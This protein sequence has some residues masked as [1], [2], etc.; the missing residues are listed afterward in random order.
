MN[1]YKLKPGL[2]GQ[3]TI[4]RD[5]FERDTQR[6]YPWYRESSSSDSVKPCYAVCP[7]CDNPI[8]LIGLYKLPPNVKLPYGKHYFRDVPDLAE[9]DP[10]S[11]KNCP[12]FTKKI[13]KKSDRKK[14]I[15]GLPQKALQLL[16]DEFDRV[17]YLLEQATRIKFS[18]R[19]I[20]NMLDRYV[21]GQG[22]LYPSLTLQNLPWIFAYMTDS[23]SIYGLKIEDNPTLVDAV[24]E[25]IPQAI[26]NNDGKVIAR[27]NDQGKNSFFQ[28]NS[29]F[30][31]HQ[32]DFNPDDESLNESMIWVV[33][34]NEGEF[35]K[36]IYRQE[37]LFEPAYFHNLLKMPPERARRQPWLVEL[38]KEKLRSLIC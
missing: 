29:C 12:Y 31:K 24:Y 4:S 18:K 8:Q 23:V 20:E 36:E 19:S 25:H 3:T 33:S 38:A 13:S 21:S 26:V 28:L 2:I 32:I 22:Y 10:E 6:K 15:N 7:S 17:I 34:T 30:I 9:S 27:T 37:I 35:P 11:A 16:V 1:V 5:N 14:S